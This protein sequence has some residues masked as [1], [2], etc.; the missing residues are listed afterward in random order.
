M[1]TYYTWKLVYQ[2]AKKSQG[3]IGVSAKPRPKCSASGMREFSAGMP[4][5]RATACQRRRVRSKSTETE[6]PSGGVTLMVAESEV[7]A[8]AGRSN[9]RVAPAR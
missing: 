9:S 5:K 8:S 6:S 7:K 1:E 3:K 4:V 2:N